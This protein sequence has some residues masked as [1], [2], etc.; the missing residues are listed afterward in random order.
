MKGLSIQI[1]SCLQSYGILMK[2]LIHKPV[3]NC[4]TPVRHE[5]GVGTLGHMCPGSVGSFQPSLQGFGLTWA[6][7]VVWECSCCSLFLPTL[8]LSVFP[9]EPSQNSSWWSKFAFSWRLRQLGV[10]H[11][12]QAFAASPSREPRSHV[13]MFLLSFP[14]I[15]LALCMFPMTPEAILWSVMLMQRSWSMLLL[16]SLS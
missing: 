13:A 5:R 16:L 11:A 12:S 10:F 9:S 7:L 1:L 15:P 8:A 14:L 4:D 3:I 6:L 2:G